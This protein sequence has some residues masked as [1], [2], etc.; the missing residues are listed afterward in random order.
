[1][2]AGVRFKDRI[3]CI[4]ELEAQTAQ[5][6]HKHLHSFHPDSRTYACSECQSAFLLLPDLRAHEKNVHAPA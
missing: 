6:L 4:Y 3:C 5:Q 1:M 2:T